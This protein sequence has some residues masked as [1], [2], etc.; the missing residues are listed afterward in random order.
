M[1]SPF[2]VFV[3]IVRRKTTGVFSSSPY[4]MTFLKSCIWLAF[5]LLRDPKTLFAV[6]LCNAIGI[7]TQFVWLMIF[8]A[9]SAHPGKCIRNIVISLVRDYLNFFLLIR[10]L[11]QRQ[12]ALICPRPDSLELSQAHAVIG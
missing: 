4:L 5:A 10:F 8:I 12:Y 7:A 11:L 9:Y 1:L 6:A 2:P 3:K